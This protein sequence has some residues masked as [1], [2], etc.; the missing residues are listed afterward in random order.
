MMVADIET[1]YSIIFDNQLKNIEKELELHIKE[2]FSQFERIDSITVRAKSPSRFATK[3]IKTNE[4]G[5]RKY[6]DPF[7]EIQDQ[8]GARITVFYL[9]DVEKVEQTI[10]KYFNHIEIQEKKPEDDSAFGYV[11]THFI[12]NI[13]DDVLPDGEARQSCPDF[14]ELQIKTLF[15]HA[16]SEAHH[17]L[18]Y[19][20]I[21]N[22]TSIEQRKVAFSAA[23]AWGA[24]MMFDELAKDL[25]EDN[26]N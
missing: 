26:D 25:V 17:D 6:K 24:D 23:Q 1:A 12:L 13:P 15:Q 18:G 22:L 11:G 21:R 2:V 4:D 5:T 16:W 3:A 19:K 8:I 9:S 10:E 7:S 14:F 20:S